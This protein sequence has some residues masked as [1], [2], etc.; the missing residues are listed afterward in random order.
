MYKIIKFKLIILKMQQEFN[1]EEYLNSLPHDVEEIRI[2]MR[3]LTYIPSLD[4]FQN[5][6]SLDCSYNLL[7]DLPQLPNKLKTG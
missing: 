7:T 4:R 6:K 5:L 2:Y 1:I 3:N